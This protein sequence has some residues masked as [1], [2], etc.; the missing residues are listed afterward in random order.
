MCNCVQLH[1]MAF[2]KIGLVDK[3]QTIN[4]RQYKAI[5]AWINDNIPGKNYQDKTQW[6]AVFAERNY[7]KTT[8]ELMSE[9][10]ISSVAEAVR[11]KNGG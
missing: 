9:D 8:V 3:D 7:G 4:Q 11:R 1:T 5:V 2:S 6:L 10:F